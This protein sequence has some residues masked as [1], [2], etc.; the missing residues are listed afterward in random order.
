MRVLSS[1]PIRKLN[2]GLSIETDRAKK[3]DDVFSI[4]KFCLQNNRC[5]DVALFGQ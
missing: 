5:Y 1:K 4:Y 2:E 3:C